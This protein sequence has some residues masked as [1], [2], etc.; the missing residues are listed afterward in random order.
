[1]IDVSDIREM[2]ALWPK[3]SDLVSDMDTVGNSVTIHQV[4]KWSESSSIPA[5]YHFHVL[6]AAKARGFDIT[7]EQMV[8]MHATRDRAA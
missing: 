8:R 5:K 4:N 3:R 6:A 7:A 2:I 1:M